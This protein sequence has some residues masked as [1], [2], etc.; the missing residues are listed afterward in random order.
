[1]ASAADTIAD[2]SSWSIDACCA[3]I[4]FPDAR[5]FSICKDETTP[6]CIL[7][8]DILDSSAIVFTWEVVDFMAVDSAEDTRLLSLDRDLRRRSC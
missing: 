4:A 8:D 5:P 6:W 3:T 1:M 2:E 7:A